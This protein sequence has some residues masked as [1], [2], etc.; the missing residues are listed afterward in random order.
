VIGG[1][2]MIAIAV[3]WFVCGLYYLDRI[4]FY[5]P[6]LFVVGVIAIVKGII[7]DE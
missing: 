2:V 7:N 3:V 5:P 1:L 6:V 4:F